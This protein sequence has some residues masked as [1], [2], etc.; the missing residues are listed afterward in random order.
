MKTKFRLHS[1]Q[2]SILT[3]IFRHQ[4]RFSIIKAAI[5][6]LRNTFSQFLH[7]NT[8]KTVL[9]KDKTNIYLVAGERKI[10]TTEQT[11]KASKRLAHQKDE[12]KNKIDK[13]HF[14]TI[15]S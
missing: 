15:K 5:K 8:T 6:K 7:I 12:Y 2:E 10:H 14:S 9:N 11:M 1:L 13:I 4:S 3:S